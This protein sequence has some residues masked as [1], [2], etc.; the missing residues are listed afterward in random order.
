V[1][2][3]A[4]INLLVGLVEVLVGL[5]PDVT[6][7]FVAELTSFGEL[8]GNYAG[9]L[10]GFLPI[11]EMMVP[12]GWAVTVYIPFVLTFYVVRWVYAKVPVVGQ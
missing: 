10:D 7:P 11:T 1:I 6:V 5:L 12:I 8:I 2:T 4:V 3:D 9:A